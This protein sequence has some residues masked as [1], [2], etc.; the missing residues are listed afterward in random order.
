VTRVVPKAGNDSEA[1]EYSIW[2]TKRVHFAA[3]QQHVVVDDYS[4]GTGGD[5][6]QHNWFTYVLT[7]GSSWSGPI[8]EA[9]VTCD[10][11]HLNCGPV[12]LLPTGAVRKGATVTWTWHDIKPKQNII[13]NW[14]PAYVDVTVDGRWI[15]PSLFDTPSMAYEAED[16]D[17]PNFTPVMSAMWPESW[18]ALMSRRRGDDVWLSVH[19]AAAWLHGQFH[20]I[21]L[22]KQDKIVRG[23]RWA[24]ATVGSSALQTP[25][26]PVTMPYAC[27]LERDP[28]GSRLAPMVSLKTVV[29]ALG[30]TYQYDPVRDHVTITMPNQ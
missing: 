20:I 28:Y 16:P 29:K 15:Y 1:E 13:V 8:G 4:G 11:S 9:V 27:A 17:A 24:L 6:G 26:G 12:G 5:A 3:G 7:T 21:T 10:L 30:G 18:G 22:G 2:W 25:S 14:Y 19:A 23:D